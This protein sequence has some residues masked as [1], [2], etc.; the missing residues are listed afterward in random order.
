M[1]EEGDETVHGPGRGEREKREGTRNVQPEGGEPRAQGKEMCGSLGGETAEPAEGW[2][3]GFPE[4]TMIAKVV[5]PCEECNAQGER[6][7][8]KGE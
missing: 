5:V 6:S 3:I 7:A 8:V 1:S 2:T 4:A